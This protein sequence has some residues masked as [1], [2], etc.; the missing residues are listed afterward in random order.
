MMLF[1]RF[2]HNGQFHTLQWLA[3]PVLLLNETVCSQ[4]NY[5]IVFLIVFFSFVS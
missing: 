1:H 3:P 4:P 5:R 2:R